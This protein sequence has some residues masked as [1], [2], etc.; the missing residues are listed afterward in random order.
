MIQ[1]KVDIFEWISCLKNAITFFCCID[2]D[3]IFSVNQENQIIS[4]FKV[5]HLALSSKKKLSIFFEN[6]GQ[7]TPFLGTLKI[8]EKSTHP[9]DVQ[10][11][12]LDLYPKFHALFRKPHGVF[13]FFP[14]ETRLYRITM[15]KQWE[16]QIMILPS[17]MD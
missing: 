11:Q 4:Q 13:Y 7:N 6:F 17:F 2:F 10:H 14:L 16:K 5:Q 3:E 15:H 12:K 1:W 8:F 9:S